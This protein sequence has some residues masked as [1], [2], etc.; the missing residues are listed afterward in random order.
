M[1]RQREPASLQALCVRQVSGA[2]AAVCRRLQDSQALPAALAEARRLRGWLCSQLAG[3]VRTLLLEDTVRQLA[4]PLLAVALLLAP[5]VPRLRAHLCCYYG[6]RGQSELL[7]L[8]AERGAGLRELELTRPSLLRLDLARLTAAL[9]QM[10]R[11][12][13]LRLAKVACDGV[14]EA[15]GG[16]CPLLALLDV[17]GSRL[18]TDAGVRSLLVQRAHI[19]DKLICDDFPPKAKGRSRGLLGWLRRKRK[20]VGKGAGKQPPLLLLREEESPL[21]ASLR[22]LLLDNTA[23]TAAGAVM[24][25]RHAPRL[26]SLG[27]LP[28]PLTHAGLPTMPQL[29]LALTEATLVRPSISQIAAVTD[30]CPHIQRLRLVQ[31]RIMNTASADLTHV[32]SKLP[33]HELQLRF[34][35][36]NAAM[37]DFYTYRDPTIDGRRSPCH[38]EDLAGDTTVLAASL[39]GAPEL[40][41]LS[42]HFSWN[43]EP[44]VVDLAYIFITCPLL[45]TLCIEG[46]S[47]RWTDSNKKVP[48]S[49]DIITAQLGS[50]VSENAVCQLLLHA[51]QLQCLHAHRCPDLK[52]TSLPPAP[53]L[54][55]LF[56]NEAPNIK[57][58]TLQTILSS[59][60][61]LERLGNMS[62]FKLDR[63]LENSLSMKAKDA[64]VE[65]LSAHHSTSEDCIF[66]DSTNN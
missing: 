18:V 66:K 37:S 11:L 35:H 39:N 49:L 20:S 46:A 45:R 34:Y 54:R 29:P 2:L 9:G 1:A 62:G 64:Q 12:R 42:V 13:E 17:R 22:Q 40:Y 65:V 52:L 19:T 32:L 5:D 4:E 31:P 58:E 25:L 43:A 24:A 8:L 30:A 27:A 26:R 3:P 28:L 33:L 51:S 47:V 15:V 36:S 41:K 7:R 23:V 6:C 44:P 56:L 50:D 10:S 60:R 38:I 59:W 57:V 21:C 55:C 48:L 61:N 16:S 63:K 53:A 14:L